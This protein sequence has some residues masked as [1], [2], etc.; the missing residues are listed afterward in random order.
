MK[1]LTYGNLSAEF[2]NHV[3]ETYP[4][5]SVYRPST[6]EELSKEIPTAQ[7]YAGFNELTGCDLSQL[8]WI[9]SFGA[10]VDAFLA[11][12]HLPSEIQISRT[13]GSMGVK[14][15]EY[16]LS[17]ILADLKKVFP[18]R[19]NQ[20]Q[21]RWQQ[22]PQVNLYDQKVLILGTGSIGQGIAQTLKGLCKS[23]AGLNRSLRHPEAFD[24]V[25]SMDQLDQIKAAHFDIVINALP[26]T[27]ATN[28]VLDA[29]FF[30]LFQN[31]HF[32]NIGRGN[33]VEDQVLLDALDAGLIRRA[34]LDVFNVEPLPSSSPLWDDERIWVTPHQ[35]GPTSMPDIIESF[36]S[37]YQAYQRGQSNE[38]FV[39]REEEY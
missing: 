6:K 7:A 29:S 28:G 16:C 39:N 20:A 21:K 9:H 22:L 4:D 3:R 10:G 18:T 38:L 11:M 1:L 24:Q 32:I 8:K 33:T 36:A 12:D 34:T 15:G 23:V 35:S 31:S 30:A 17:Y 25:L 37:A 27:S 2:E 13:T 14:I 19:H 5:I 26:K